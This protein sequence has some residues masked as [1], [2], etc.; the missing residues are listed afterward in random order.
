MGDPD[1]DGVSNF[2][3]FLHGTSPGQTG[4]KEVKGHV[5]YV[6]NVH[7]SD[8]NTGKFCYPV[9][10]DGPK[11]SIKAAIQAAPD[12]AVIVVLKGTGTYHEGSYGAKGKSFTLTT[13]DSATIQ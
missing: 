4:A 12:D 9:G 3:E 5:L 7:G 1:G 13:L 11:A 6:D 2:E 10:N 8:G